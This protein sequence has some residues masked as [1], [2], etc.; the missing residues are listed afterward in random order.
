[1]PCMLPMRPAEDTDIFDRPEMHDRNAETRRVMIV[2]GGGL[3]GR[4]LAQVF[5]DET[6]WDVVLATRTHLVDMKGYER[7]DSD[8]RSEWKRIVL[9][10]RWK[11]NVIVNAAAMTNVDKCE[12]ERAEAWKAN[13][14]LVEIITEM[15]R[16]ID[17]WLVQISSDYI[18]DGHSG[19][20]TELDRPA[21]INYYGK[22]KLAAENVCLRS[23]L[24]ST[25]VRT[26][27]LYGVAG[28]GK[29]TFSD[30]IV[31]SLKNGES[32]NVVSD[33]LGNPTF[34][35][36]VSYGVL[37]L[38]ERGVQGVVNVAGPER[39]SRMDWAEIVCKVYGIEPGKQLNAI[40]SGQLQRKAPRPIKSGLVTTKASSSLEFKGLSVVDGTSTVKITTERLI[41]LA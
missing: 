11:P 19:P 39:M 20:Y 1:M 23:G 14:G 21:P 41:E 6:D 34:V 8:S 35:D 2:G 15:C 31:E 16:K 10:E 38:I 40:H 9:S 12:T 24:E 25:I 36:D 26:M 3:L 29:K 27:W 37:K 28:E 5:R 13:V 32:I 33:E 18:F 7:W 4:S 22:T 30:W 17:A